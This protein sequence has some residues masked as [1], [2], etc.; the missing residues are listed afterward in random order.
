MPKLLDER[1]G[2][3]KGLKENDIYGNII[4]HS[5]ANRKKTDVSYEK[6]KK[7][8]LKEL[9]IEIDDEVSTAL[10]LKEEDSNSQRKVSILLK[11]SLNIRMDMNISKL[12]KVLNKI[13]DVEKL[14]D[15]YAMSFLKTSSKAGVSNG[16]LNDRLCQTLQ[17]GKYEGFEIL[18][19][20]YLVY[21]FQSIRYIKKL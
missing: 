15:R 14:Q 1:A 7:T 13:Y 19:E 8:I 21:Y 18:G 9:A 2:V 17:G 4:E 6:K 11:D 12:K 16:E 20:D 10:G 3:I 5:K